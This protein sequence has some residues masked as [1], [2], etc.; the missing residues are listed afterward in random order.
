M[1]NTWHQYNE[2]LMIVKHYSD[3]CSLH[4]ISFY[5]TGFIIQP[6]GFHVSLSSTPAAV[7]NGISNLRLFFM[8]VMDFVRETSIIRYIMVENGVLPR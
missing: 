3:F 7:F 8:A 4:L 1:K 5:E 6:S 2:R